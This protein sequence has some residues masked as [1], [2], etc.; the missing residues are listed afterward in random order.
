MV[1]ITKTVCGSRFWILD[2]LPDYIN[3]WVFKTNRILGTGKYLSSQPAPSGVTLRYIVAGNWKIRMRGVDHKACPGDIFCALPSESIFFQQETEDYWEWLEIQL[4]GQGAEDFLQE[5]GLSPNA[6]VI[7]PLNSAKAQELFH[8]IYY[9][10]DQKQRSI[11]KAL[12]LLFELV[13][14]CGPRKVSETEQAEKSK[15]FMVAKAMD[16]IETQ[17]SSKINVNQLAEELGVDRTTLFR[18]FIEVKGKSPHAYIDRSRLERARELLYSTDL[19]IKNIAQYCGFK[20][21]KYFIGWFKKK[22]GTTPASY[23]KKTKQ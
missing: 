22:T 5:F 1:G 6:P 10:M 23:R 20:D 16:H 3:I 2:P 8:E 14:I 7:K 4:N 12:A 15:D 18:A 9:L 19:T 17:L 21:L 11:H 13:S